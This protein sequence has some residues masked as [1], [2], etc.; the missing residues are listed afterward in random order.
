MLI[1]DQLATHRLMKKFTVLITVFTCLSLSFGCSRKRSNAAAGAPE[2]LVAEVARK[3]VPVVKEWVATLDGL[4][5][6]TISARVAGHLISQDY[7]EGTAVKKGDPLFQIDPRPFE[8]ALAQAKAT[9]AKAQATQLKADQDEKR[10]VELFNRK[11]TSE[12]E[13]DT[14]LQAAAATKG[15]T[16]ADQAAVNSAELNLGYTKIT[17]P[18]DGIAGFAAAQV[19]DLVGPSTAPL[20]TISQVDPIKA[21]VTAGEQSYSEFTTRYSD[22]EKRDQYVKS[23]EFELVLANGSVYPQKGK[24]YAMDRNVDVK[25]GSIRF[26]TTFPNP[27]NI[28]RPGQFGRV[29]ATT[30]TRKGAL[31]VPQEAVTELQGNYQVAV[32]GSDN[33]A[34]IHPVKVGDRFGAM[35]EI[36][37]GVEP[38]EQVV[39]QGIQKVREGAPVTAKRWMPPAETP[40]LAEAD[41]SKHP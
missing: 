3:D 27:G 17:A 7:K 9:L 37:E 33:K 20:T 11:V 32:I 5:N 23:V 30:E 16:E 18:I 15:D 25:T 39:V 26:E 35:W 10:A 8:E 13:R 19:G 36:T 14:A 24:F 41:K 31:L 29:R 38:G 28:L 2:V 21:V 22:P 12:Q 34:S 4:V 1:S 6:A 40:A